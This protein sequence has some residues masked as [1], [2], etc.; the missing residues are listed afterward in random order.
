MKNHLIIL[1][2]GRGSRLKLNN[3]PKALALVNDKPIIFYL[4]DTVKGN[5]AIDSITIV[6]GHL[7]EDIKREVSKNYSGIKF[8]NQDPLDGTGGAILQTIKKQPFEDNDRLIV[9]QAD[10]SWRYTKG[11]IES[12]IDIDIE[13]FG[14]MVTESKDDKYNYYRKI[15]IDEKNNFIELTKEPQID[16]LLVCGSYIG[17]TKVYKENLSMLEANP[18][19]EI[20]LPFILYKIKPEMVQ[21]LKI[22][23]S[24]WH[25]INTPEELDYANRR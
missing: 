1:A 10:D 22:Y 24:H 2:A 6:I 16:G 7:G 20:G 23:E 15:L 12:L 8:V 5:E 3:K 4:L 19:G 14:V 17:K 25:G 18:N 21:I 9:F 11:D 13:K